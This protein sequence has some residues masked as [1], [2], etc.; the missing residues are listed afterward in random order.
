MK[1]LQPGG[2]S[3]VLYAYLLQPC[4][5]FIICTK[6]ELNRLAALS[7]RML[8]L[9]VPTVISNS[10]KLTRL[11]ICCW[12]G[13]E[14]Q[15]THV[16]YFLLRE[17]LKKSSFDLTPCRT[18]WHRSLPFGDDTQE[19]APVYVHFVIR[20]CIQRSLVLVLLMWCKA[21]TSFHR[22]SGAE[23]RMCPVCTH[24]HTPCGRT[25]THR[26]VHAQ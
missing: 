23:I 6:T 18:F 15:L 26:G 17:C 16:E 20:V 5:K 25:H 3:P 21:F 7:T 8:L 10:L 2:W 13:P 22:V 11:A 24:T 19:I 12:L 1:L 4:A 14:H 9:Y